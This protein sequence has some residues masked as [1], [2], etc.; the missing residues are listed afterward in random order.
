MHDIW[1]C[2]IME[3]PHVFC[4]NFSLEFYEE[5]IQ[6][7]SRQIFNHK[8][9]LQNAHI[10]FD[11]HFE[12]FSDNRSNSAL[13]S[14]VITARANLI[15]S[16]GEMETFMGNRAYWVNQAKLAYPGHN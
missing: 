8:Y 10:A 11:I 14:N 12:Q 3:S 2:Y 13:R 1:V 16:M 6:V 4:A 9:A 7:I 5:K 15:R